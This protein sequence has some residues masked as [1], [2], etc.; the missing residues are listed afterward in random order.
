[1]PSVKALL[2]LK[3]TTFIFSEGITGEEGSGEEE[4]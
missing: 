4:G 1:M 2:G 3:G